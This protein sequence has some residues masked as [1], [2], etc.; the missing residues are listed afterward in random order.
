MHLHGAHSDLSDN[1][2]DAL[3]AET[4]QSYVTATRASKA[5]WARALQLVTEEILIRLQTVWSFATGAFGI[6]K[7]PKYE[8]IQASD[9]SLY[10]FQQSEVAQQTIAAHAAETTSNIG[11]GIA[12]GLGSGVTIGL[13][14]LAVILALKFK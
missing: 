7:F 3:Y 12:I 8:K 4:Y 6:T 2:L 5:T 9:P 11:S 1:D 14:A 10:G 13:I